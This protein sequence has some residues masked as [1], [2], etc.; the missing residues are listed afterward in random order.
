MLLI[1]SHFIWYLNLILTGLT[2]FSI[3]RRYPDER[4][5]PQSRNAV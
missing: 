5:E 4:S 3:I 2:G 1:H